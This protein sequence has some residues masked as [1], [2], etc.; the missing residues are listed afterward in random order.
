LDIE[1]TLRQVLDSTLGLQGRAGGFTRDTP[2]LG[3]LPELDSMAVAYLITALEE[4]FGIAISD[5]EIDGAAF[6]TFGAL[7]QF[8]RRHVEEQTARAVG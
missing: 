8:T 7:V 5:D 2:L 4:Q 1:R 6:E 3:A